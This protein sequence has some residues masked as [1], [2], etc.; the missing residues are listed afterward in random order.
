MESNLKNNLPTASES[1]RQ[2]GSKS[3]FF[4]NAESQSW[5][6]VPIHSSQRH[7][8]PTPSAVVDVG[9]DVGGTFTDFVG[10]RGRDVV[11]RKLPSTTNPEQA[12]IEGMQDLGAAGMAHVTTVATDRVLERQRTRTAFVT[13]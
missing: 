3:P 13:T 5:R 1:A 6:Q 7:E 10:F 9:V 4:R 12:V 8:P 2:P 11:T